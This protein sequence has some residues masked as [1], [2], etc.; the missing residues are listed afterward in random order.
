M[1]LR[2]EQPCHL[3]NPASPDKMTDE[4][5]RPRLYRAGKPTSPSNLKPRA[6]DQGKLS[7]RDTLSNPWPLKP[8]Q[9]PVFEPGDAYF[10]IDG[11]KLPSGTIVPDDD[12]P[13]HVFVTDVTP[14]EIQQAVVERGRFPR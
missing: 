14:E 12:P 9:R 3:E 1:T 6:I 11:S 2:P 13:G 7:F 8:G 4:F 10:G 5:L